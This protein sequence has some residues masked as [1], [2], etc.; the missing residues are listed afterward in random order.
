M[1]EMGL[2]CAKTHARDTRSAFA[3]SSESQFTSSSSRRRPFLTLSSSSPT[4][5][6][7]IRLPDRRLKTG[8]HSR[9]GES[10]S[11]DRAV[12]ASRPAHRARTACVLQ[13]V[14]AINMTTEYP[15]KAVHATVATNPKI[16]TANAE[17]RTACCQPRRKSEDGF[18]IATS[19]GAGAITTAVFA[20]IVIQS[21]AASLPHT[22]RRH[23]MYKVQCTIS[24]TSI[25]KQSNPATAKF[26]SNDR[27]ALMAPGP[28]PGQAFDVRPHMALFAFRK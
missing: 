17:M 10:L 3:P 15:K 16:M 20:D 4:P 25:S 2:G 13:S 5:A 24:C 11:R 26:K 12:A 14:N 1:S 19:T 23:S 6:P 27:R 9:G 28:A 22:S 8:G 21:I 18:G 7:L